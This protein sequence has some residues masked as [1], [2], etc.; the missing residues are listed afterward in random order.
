MLEGTLKRFE[1]EVELRWIEKGIEKGKRQRNIELAKK[2]L[3]EG[4]EIEFI[5]KI[6]EMR[7]DEIKK[8]MN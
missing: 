5:A 4:V 2:M 1:E 6:C 7:I 8:F 3:K